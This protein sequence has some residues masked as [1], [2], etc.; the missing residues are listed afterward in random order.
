MK[1]KNKK[2]LKVKD[3]LSKL[4]PT[5]FTV[6]PNCRTIFT[7]NVMQAPP[8]PFFVSPALKF[9]SVESKNL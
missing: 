6:A 9:P 3:F 1:N 7:K 2:F 8:A 5:F 4:A